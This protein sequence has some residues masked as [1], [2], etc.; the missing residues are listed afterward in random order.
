MTSDCLLSRYRDAILAEQLQHLTSLNARERMRMR[1]ITK[2]RKRLER[3]IK[4]RLALST[5]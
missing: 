2:E 3:Q 5:T 1:A 4:S